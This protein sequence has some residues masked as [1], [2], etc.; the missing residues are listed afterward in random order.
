M[1]RAGSPEAG[2]ELRGN[3]LRVYLYILQH[4]PCELKDVQGGLG[5]STASLASYHLGRLIDRGYA[6]QDT[7]GRYLAAKDATGQ[8]LEGYV[9]V[10]TVVVP[11]LL[12]V[13]VLFT[14]LVS[15][16]SV[17][18]Y[19]SAS[20]VPLLVA[21]SVALVAV[22]WYETTRVWRRLASWR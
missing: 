7:Y 14:I 2:P 17:M 6:S 18:T 20:Y 12:F 3:T 4:G 16:F 22:V 8:I 15:Y 9:K 1:K 19:R 11:Q 21:S 5:F 10:G 13:S